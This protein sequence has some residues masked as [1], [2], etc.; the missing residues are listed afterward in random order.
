MNKNI[1]ITNLGKLEYRNLLV[2]FFSM[3]IMDVAAQNAFST[4]AGAKGIGAGNANLTYRD[5]HSGFNNQAG[6]A[7]LEGFS[8]AAYAENRFLL[9]ELQLAA[10][11]IAKPTNAG[12]WGMML[13][14]FGFEEYNE[15][16][17]GLSYSRKLFDKLAI[18]AQFDFLNTQIKEYGSAAAITFEIGLQY[19]ILDKLTTGIH[20]FNPIRATIGTQELPAILQI[21][22]TYRPTNYI[23]ISG[24]VEKDSTLPYTIRMGLEYQVL[25]K[26]QFRAGFNSNPNRLSFGLGYTV[27]R[28]Q[29]NVAAS[30]HDVLGFSPALGVVFLPVVGPK[31]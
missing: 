31:S 25:E 18:G 7:Y 27:N 29:L 30:Y 2:L 16:K 4:A 3:V 19:E 14:Y 26:I 24:S 23:A 1:T 28:M 9:K 8:G 15:Q 21:G 11:S 22:L 20:I 6:L 10:I 5:I 17:V 12:T 13:Q